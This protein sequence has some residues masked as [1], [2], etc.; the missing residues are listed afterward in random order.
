QQGV[1]Y[2]G[3]DGGV[4]RSEQ[5]GADGTWEHQP[6]Q[7]WSQ[8][9]TL[10]VSP[11]DPLRVNGGVQDNGSLRTWGGAENEWNSYYGGDGVKNAI[12]PKDKQNV[13]ACS[14]YGACGRSDNGGDSMSDMT[15]TSARFGW[16]SPI[17]FQPGSA[18]V[19]YWAGSEVNK[20]EDRG[21]TWTSISPDLGEGDAGREINPL[22]AAHYGTVQ[23]LGLN[24]KK[25]NV[26]YAGTD[27][28]LLWKT[29][30]GGANWTK[31][32][33]KSLPKRWVTH[34]EVKRNN[35]RVVYLTY[36]GYRQ[37]DQSPY[38]LKSRDGGKTW[39][40]I[41]GNLP[42]APVNDL[43]LVR[44]KLYLASDVGVFRSGVRGGKWLKVGS[45]LPLSP[46]ND[47]RYVRKGRLLFAATFGH[48]IFKASI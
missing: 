41:T 43:L 36:S 40:N 34:L 11:Q 21:Q 4:Y 44:K 47:L 39:K 33:S 25:P 35:P 32:L 3:N 8:F 42:K 23:A 12:N 38:V 28:G 45:N 22:Y 15:Q 48:G 20:S 37:G 19:M 14:Q 2:N 16:L 30:D 46:I 24:K 31:L 5:N 9:F 17:E 18:D 10:D 29:K 13:F 27:N 6:Y 26:I 7:P 1:V